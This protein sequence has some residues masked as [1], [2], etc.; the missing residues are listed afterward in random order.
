MA[1]VSS[2]SASAAEPTATGIDSNS[3]GS[4]SSVIPRVARSAGTTTVWN[5]TTA[6]SGSTASTL[7]TSWAVRSITTPT[8]SY[9]LTT[10]RLPGWGTRR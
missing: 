5:R 6:A 9:L 4:M 3:A 8:A 2:A 1:G 10:T 7:V